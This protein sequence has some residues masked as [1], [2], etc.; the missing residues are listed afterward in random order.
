MRKFKVGDV[1]RV[2]RGES[3]EYNGLE[4]EV[5]SNTRSEYRPYI[6]KMP[7]GHP[8]KTIFRSDC[9][10][11]LVTPPPASPIR[12][13]TRR[14]IVPG[15]YGAVSIAQSSC[16]ELRY[17]IEPYATAEQLR[18]AAHTLNQLAE[19]LEEQAVAA[20]C[21]ATDRKSDWIEWHGGKCPVEDLT[22]VEVSFGDEVH[23][24]CAE[25]FDWS[26]G[27][28]PD[29]DISAYRVLPTSSKTP[30]DVLP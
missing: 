1:V 30:W 6:L 3:P 20:C 15:I 27:A 13:V 14:E 28:G 19:V 18:E 12:T 26:H 24:G 10:L 4:L 22:Q 9:D 11:E 8:D 29:F 16:G 23:M 2:L 5:I 25:D 21:E 17:F 7:A